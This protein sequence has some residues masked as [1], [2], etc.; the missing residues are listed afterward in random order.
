MTPRP[1]ASMELLNSIVNSAIDPDYGPPVDGSPRKSGVLAVVGM[2]LI[3]FLLGSAVV[4]NRS[5][6]L[7]HA[8][9]RSE[10][11]ER[12][13]AAQTTVGNLR[14]AQSDLRGEVSRLGD[15]VLSADPQRGLRRELAAM[16]GVDAVSGPGILVT[17][18][19]PRSGGRVIDED[20]AHVVSGLFQ[21]GAEA[22]AINDHRVTA[23]TAIQNAGD[24][25]TVNYVSLV[26]PYRVAA[27]GDPKLLSAKFAETEAA[28]RIGYL[29]DNYQISERIDTVDEL[30][31]AGDGDLT[32][33]YTRVP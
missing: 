12:I 24:A 27:I 16:S 3:G 6:A 30:E 17:L 15:E 13:R 25:I 26:S 1:D 14:Q 11:V 19:D 20:L 29:R 18:D 32:L 9:E 7:D 23:R 33:T 4:Q 28:A 22:V 31:L 5:D 10:L 2:V 21:A 8:R